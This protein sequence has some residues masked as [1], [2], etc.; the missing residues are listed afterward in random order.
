MDSWKKLSWQEACFSVAAVTKAPLSA[1]PK[2]RQSLIERRF[3][4]G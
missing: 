3:V 4:P 1:E 2:T